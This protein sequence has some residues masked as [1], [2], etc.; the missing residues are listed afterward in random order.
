[1]LS[2][3]VVRLLLLTG[4]AF[5]VGLIMTPLVTRLLY[6]YKAGK[7]IRH[8]SDAPVYFKLHQ[9]KAGTPTMGGIIIWATVLGL[10]ALF[11]VLYLLFDHFWDYFNIID[12]AQTYLPIAAMLIAALLGAFDDILG[13]LK[14]GPKGGGMS[15][16]HKL[17]I[18]F[19]IALVGGFWFSVKLGWSALY[20]PFVGSVE[21][22][23]WYFPIFIFI[24]VASAF[25]PM[26]LTASMV[27]W[28]VHHC[29]LLDR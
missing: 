6:R 1:M 8:S 12:R 13:I 5:L 4:I 29:F 22:D 16:R 2:F 25:L 9:D 17:V 21:I 10:A 14:I 27:C 20:I 11:F 3:Q 24:L 19:L 23:G 26:R 15:V 28:G 7:Q 18:Y